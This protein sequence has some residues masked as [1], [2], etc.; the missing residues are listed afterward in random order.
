[1]CMYVCMFVSNLFSDLY[2]CSFTF[3]DNV[4]QTL[5]IKVI[6]TKPQNL[7]KFSLRFSPY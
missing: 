3:S 5:F 1:M 7:M 6:F 2:I 4:I